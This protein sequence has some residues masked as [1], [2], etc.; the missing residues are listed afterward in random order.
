MNCNVIQLVLLELSSTGHGEMV[1]ILCIPC[2]KQLNIFMH[3]L[4]TE[5]CLYES[6]GTIQCSLMK[7]L[8]MEELLSVCSRALV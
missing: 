8:A 1:L 3:L 5:E 6:L 4:R 2:T 7:S